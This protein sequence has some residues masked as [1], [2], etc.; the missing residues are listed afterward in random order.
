MYLAKIIINISILL[1][2]LPPFKQLKGGYFLYFLTL[3]YSDPLAL[4]LG[5]LFKISP[6][7]THLIIAFILLICILYYTNKL[8][9]KWIISL[10]LLLILSL[11][12]GNR[13]IRYISIIIIHCLIFVQ[14][15][16][17]TLLEFFNGHRINTYLSVLLVYELMTALKYAAFSFNYFSGVYFFYISLAFETVIC[18]FFIF[19]NLNNTPLINLPF[20][21]ITEK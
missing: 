9:Y 7:Y 3:G 17:P 6:N 1:W 21:N 12:S 19:V 8:N 18:I 2:L 15:L 10:F 11:C 13:D 5:W 16:I 4:L 20:I 14:I